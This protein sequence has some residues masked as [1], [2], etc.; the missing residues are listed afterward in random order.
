VVAPTFA[1]IQLVIGS[2]YVVASFGF[3]R[4]ALRRNDE[5]FR[6]L[7]LACVLSVFSRINYFLYPSS[8]TDWVY[9]GDAFRLSFFA[10]LLVAGLGEIATYWREAAA[11]A[12]LNERTR[13]ARAL[14]DGV[15]QEVAF[16]R[17]SIGSAVEGDG[18]PDLHQRLAAAAERAERESR[19]L[20]A[21]LTAQPDET[22]EVLLAVVVREVAVRER[23]DVDLDAAAGLRLDHLRA[24]ALLRIA[25]EAVT[26]AARH[27]ATD[28]VRVTVE[29]IGD[30]V[31]MR[32][33][34]HGSGFDP[35]APPPGSAARGFGLISMRARAQAIGAD[36]SLS[37][38]PANGTTVEVVS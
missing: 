4:R 25:A 24:E 27:A 1:A 23:V 28:S 33:I 29:R 11:A 36:F 6:W 5:F 22:F 38:R 26:N 13:L 15:A 30:R 21:A 2:L 34:D 19:Q 8:Y 32:V 18:D 14:H 9:L 35:L 31:R 20:L 3:M 7:A 12:V 10:L 16:L 37:S 17:G